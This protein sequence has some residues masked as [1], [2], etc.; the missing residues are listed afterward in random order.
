M[1]KSGGTDTNVLCMI[2]TN[3]NITEVG[4]VIITINSNFVISNS[5]TNSV[6]ITTNCT[7]N[8]VT[9]PTSVC[10][11]NLNYMIVVA[12]NTGYLVRHSDGAVFSFANVGV[13][14]IPAGFNG[15]DVVDTDSSGNIYLIIGT[16][17][18]KINTQNPSILT[19]TPDMAANDVTVFCF[20]V[21]A[22]GNTVYNG[23]DSSG[24]FHLRAI[25]AIGYPLGS[26]SGNTGSNQTFF[27]LGLDG[28]IYYNSYIDAS[29]YIQLCSF[30]GGSFSS[31]DWNL[32]IAMGSIPLTICKM[33]GQSTILAVENI[34]TVVWSIYNP[35]NKEAFFSGS[36]LGLS[37]IN[38]AVSSEK[39]CYLAGLDLSSNNVLVKFDPSKNTAS[40]VTAMSGQYQIYVMSVS[41]NDLLTFNALD[42][43]HNCTVFGTVDNSGNVSIIT[44]NLNNFQ[45]TVLAQVN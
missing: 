29:S 15:G 12:N 38:L 43:K 7:T 34:T 16:K 36:F 33:P 24:N 31:S 8:S 30:S 17:L 19:A 22:G 11:A 13:P 28:N 14:D 35:T 37:A 6:F 23:E 41:S 40:P 2:D 1:H 32:N 4:D 9:D 3:G 5:V 18:M 26:P 10:V 20:A 27:W 44:T 25:P 45:A 39:Y 42:M 21:D